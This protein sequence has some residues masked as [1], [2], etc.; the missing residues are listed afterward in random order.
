MKAFGSYLAAISRHKHLAVR[1]DSSR[2]F[3]PL[4]LADLSLPLR[5]GAAV[6]F[7]TLSGLQIVPT[8]ILPPGAGS[9]RLAALGAR[10]GMREELTRQPS[11]QGA[12]GSSLCMWAG[13]VPNGHCAAARLSPGLLTLP[14]HRHP[15]NSLECKGD[16]RP[17]FAL[18]DGDEKLE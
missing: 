14:K 13:A 1:S 8:T 3:W 4:I 16:I 12:P 11:L 9:L 7:W 6:V 17:N 2:A 10:S 18:G 5:R 15:L